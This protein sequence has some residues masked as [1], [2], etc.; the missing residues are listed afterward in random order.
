LSRL[1]VGA[2]TTGGLGAIEVRVDAGIE[3]VEDVG[4]VRAG[5]LVSLVVANVTGV[6]GAGQARALVGAVGVTLSTVAVRVDAG[7]S[8]V[9]EAGVMRTRGVGVAVVTSK[10]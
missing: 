7:I 2:V 5:S 4:S 3:L 1:T 10:A 8:L 6:V 9:G